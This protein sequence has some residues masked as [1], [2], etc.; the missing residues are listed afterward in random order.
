MRIAKLV[1]I[2]LTISF[3]AFLIERSC[4]DSNEVDPD[5]SGGIAQMMQQR[6][7]ESVTASAAPTPSPEEKSSSQE[8]A[9]KE[10]S[11]IDPRQAYITP[12]TD[13]A[14]SEEA[15]R[16]VQGTWV[17]TDGSTT[18]QLTV[19]NKTGSLKGE[20]SE[21]GKSYRVEQEAVLFGEG[22]MVYVFSS[23]PIIDN[24]LSMDR[25]VLAFN[26]KEDGSADVVWR[27]T[28]Q[29]RRLTVK[30]YVK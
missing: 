30:S 9:A 6:K 7:S 20:I 12:R 17:L 25:I 23:E 5:R 24:D 21:G 10:W 11:G 29:S 19:L 27:R 16:K 8:M 28:D 1:L 2:L 22:N 26:F 13:T 18:F 3:S 14:A 15:V 4:H